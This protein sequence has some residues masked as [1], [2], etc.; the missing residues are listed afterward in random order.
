MPMTL[1]WIAVGGI[2]AVALGYVVYSCYR[3]WFAQAPRACSSGCGQ[4]QESSP[5]SPTRHG[6]RPLPMA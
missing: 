1:Q 3:S 5:D 4:C 2:V 6:R